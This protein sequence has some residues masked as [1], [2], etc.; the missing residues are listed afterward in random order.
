MVPSNS[1]ITPPSPGGNYEKGKKQNKPSAGQQ[2]EHKAALEENAT[3]GVGLLMPHIPCSIRG[4]ALSA[5]PSRVPPA[6]ASLTDTLA[7]TRTAALAAARAAA[8]AAALAA[9]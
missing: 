3:Q 4:A 9:V 6:R 2:G 7:V 1:E 5:V 8:R